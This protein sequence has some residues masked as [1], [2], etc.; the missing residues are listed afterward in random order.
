MGY[1]DDISND[2]DFLLTKDGEGLALIGILTLAWALK[3]LLTGFTV[4]AG[5]VG[6]VFASSIWW[7]PSGICFCL[8]VNMVFGEGTIPLGML[9]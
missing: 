5:G 7:S 1:S 3:P 9:S 8:G 2:L 4:G 6:G